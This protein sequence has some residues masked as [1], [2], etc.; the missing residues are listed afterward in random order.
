MVSREVRERI[1]K[2]LSA[3]KRPHEDVY[4]RA[5]TLVNQGEGV[6]RDA[7]TGNDPIE[8]RAAIFL[9]VGFS[10]ATGEITTGD[11]TGMTKNFA[12]GLLQCVKTSSD[13][14]SMRLA[15]RALF[16]LIQ[17]SKSYAVEIAEMVMKECKDWLDEKQKP[18]DQ[19]RLCTLVLMRD[20]ALFTRQYFLRKAPSYFGYIFKFIRDYTKHR[21]I[22][23]KS[24][25]AALT[26]ISQ[27]EHRQKNEWYQKCLE[28]ARMKSDNASKEDTLYASLLIYNE[29]M[30]IGFA[31]SEK[32]RLRLTETEKEKPKNIADTNPVTWLLDEINPQ[33]VESH[34]AQTMVVNKLDEIQ[35]TVNEAKSYRS[36]KMQDILLEIYPRLV[37][38]CKLINR[39]MSLMSL[40]PGLMTMAPKYTP[41]FQC[42]GL[43]C[44]QEKSDT[45]FLL[46]EKEPNVID[47][48]I[49]Y[50]AS[51]KPK[52]GLKPNDEPVLKFLCC[53]IESH[54]GLVISRIKEILPHMFNIGFAEGIIEALHYVVKY[55]PEMTTEVHD[56][57]LD[58]LYKQLMHQPR[59]NKLAPPTLPPVPPLN[60]YSIK[61]DDVPTMVLALKALGDFD[62]QRHSLQM[63][64]KYLT[65]AYFYCDQIEIRL[66]AV[67][68]CAKIVQPFIRIYDKLEKI[69]KAEIF[70]RIRNILESLIK[71]AVVDKEVEVR[72][73]VINAFATKD[74]EFLVHLAQ[75]DL[76]D[77]LFMT[78]YDEN[79]A[80]QEAAVGLIGA[81]AEINPAYVYPKLRKVLQETI[82]QLANSKISH[83]EEQS[84]KCIAVLA[85]KS[86]RFVMPYMYNILN[87]LEPHLIYERRT[88]GVTVHVLD[89]LSRLAPLGGMDIVSHLK[90]LFKPL[91]Q[92]LQDATSLYRREASLRAMGG[93]CQST[94]YIVDPYKDYPELLDTLLK[95]LKTELNANMRRLTIKTIGIIGALDPYTYKVFLGTVSSSR[96]RTLAVSLPTSPESDDPRLDI[97]RWINYERCTLDQFYPAI[98]IAT[99]IEMMQDEALT[100]LHK[101]IVEALFKIFMEL[102]KVNL[103]QYVDQV[104]PKLIT[105]TENANPE[106]RQFYL[107]QLKKLAPLFKLGIKSYLKD[108]FKLIATTWE[109]F[110]PMRGIVITL[111]SAIGKTLGTDFGPYVTDLCPYLLNV[112]QMDNTREKQLTKKALE[113]VAAIN[114][115]LDPHLHLIVPPIIYVIDDA[116]NT[117][118]EPVR[119]TALDTLIQILYS[120]SI[121][122]RAPLVMQMW[123]RNMS[124]KSFQDR[125]MKVLIRI[126]DQMWEQ[127]VAYCDAVRFQFLKHKIPDHQVY[128]YYEKVKVFCQEKADDL[129]PI[130]SNMVGDKQ[131]QM[132]QFPVQSYSPTSAKR[133]PLNSGSRDELKSFKTMTETIQENRRQMMLPQKPES[134]H[135]STP[136]HLNIPHLR[137]VWR[138]PLSS[139]I[140]EDWLLWIDT[141]RIEFLKHSPATSLNC[142]GSLAEAY[143]QLAK[144]LF[145]ASFMSV[146]TKLSTEEHTEIAY[147]FAECLRKC[148]YG[149]ATQAILNLAE[150]MD[151]SEKGPLPVNYPL[152]SESA[153][154]VQA[155]AKA[156]RYK[157]LE[158]WSRAADGLDNDLSYTQPLPKDC[159]QIISY[160]K[161]LNLEELALGVITYAKHLDMEVS[162]RWHEKL[163]Q[164][165]TALE[166]YKKEIE[167][168]TDNAEKLAYQLRLMRCH[169][170]LGNWNELNHLADELLKR[171]DLD[172]YSGDRDTT[173]RKQ[174]ILQIASRGAW[175]TGDFKKMNQITD[176]LNENTVEGSFLR[177]VVAVKEANY[178]TAINYIGKVRDIFDSELTAMATESYERAY[179]AIVIAQHLTELEEAIEYRT[180]PERK[181]RIAIL[182]SRRLQGM[183]LDVEQWHKTLIIRQLV[184]S[185]DELRPMWIKFAGLC[186]KRGKPN[187]ANRVLLNL[188]GIKDESVRLIEVPFPADKPPLALA[189]C[190]QLWNENYK[191]AAIEKLEVLTAN[192]NKLI[193]HNEAFNRMTRDQ[194]EPYYRVTAKCYLK[195]GDWQ[196]MF[197][198]GRGIH[199]ANQSPLPSRHPSVSSRIHTPTGIPRQAWRHREEPTEG[200]KQCYLMA[201]KLYKC[202]YKA[203]QRLAILY[204]NLVMNQTRN[205]QLEEMQNNELGHQQG[206][207]YET[208]ME[209]RPTGF[210]GNATPPDFDGDP[211][212]TNFVIHAEDWTENVRPVSDGMYMEQMHPSPGQSIILSP[213]SIGQC[214]RD[215]VICYFKAIQLAEGSRMEDT[216][217]LLMLLID[218]GHRPELSGQDIKD[219]IRKVTPE[220]WLEVAPQLIARLDRDDCVGALIKQLM[221]DV[222]KAHPHGLIYH[223]IAATRAKSEVRQRAAMEILET[224]RETRPEIVEKGLMLNEELI[225][226]AILWHELWHEALEDAS[227]IYFSAESDRNIAEM[228]KVLQPLHDKLNQSYKTLK[229]HSFIQTYYKDLSDAH[230][231]CEAYL[232]SKNQK[233][234]TQAWDLY[235]NVFKRISHQL[236]QLNSLDLNYVSPRLAEAKNLELCVPGTYDPNGRLIRIASIDHNL[237]VILSKQRPRK[238]VMRGDDGNEYIFLLKGHEDPRQDERVMQLFG[239]INSLILKDPDTCRRDL[240]IQ[241]YAI[242]GLSQSSGLIGWVPNCD[243]LHALIKDYREKKGIP[244]SV[245]HTEMQKLCA[246]YEKL[247]LMQ[248]VEVFREALRVTQ[249]ND[250]R[251]TL[252]MKSPTSE[253]WFDR[254]T[255]FTRSVACMSMVGYILGLGDRHPSNVMLDRLSGK[256]VHIDFGDC[257]EVAMRREK[258]PEKVPFR[259]TR[260]LI[261][262]ME[263]TGIEGNYRITC[264]RILRLIRQNRYSILAVLEAFVYD[265]VLNWFKIPD[266]AAMKGRQD[267]PIGRNAEQKAHDLLKQRSREAIERVKV[268]LNGYDFLPQQHIY[269]TTMDGRIQEMNITTHVDRL[270]EQA[271]LAENLCQCYI[272]F[273]PFW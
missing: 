231:F 62:F 224:V 265:P 46:K 239:L 203:W 123:L 255:N 110:P 63:F 150:F 102:P 97:I 151:H 216:L 222:A 146:W 9:V 269:S 116:E 92:H 152:L 114:P 86:P 249:G 175:T 219:E 245:E 187:I 103:N 267:D 35:R 272:G 192:L 158:M 69:Q 47:A 18:T 209:L 60:S 131:E 98:T 215:A 234:I 170:Q 256:I 16:Y 153:A 39:P 161:R 68:C 104:L 198:S 10:A 154:Q 223:L 88:I 58:L 84:A 3:L 37:G 238:L 220:T 27:R 177:A 134:Y 156:L 159:Q 213:D 181:T 183:S 163:G 137:Q 133:I 140:R 214:A 242:I 172:D 204:Y 200:V 132:Q 207:G 11:E 95:L 259:L 147:Q 271:T 29:I 218:H 236:R 57:L 50:I 76:L 250:L 270:I 73:R 167:L 221:I 74:R 201:T 51:L 25:H 15:S 195:L 260:M 107:D 185:Q 166:C 199:S 263:V 122:E 93:L 41:V 80:I 202:W 257:F 179:G 71:L 121:G 19:E 78:V 79:P 85:K 262:A 217:R 186:R 228:M 148:P 32:L 45:E 105:L 77:V 20:F 205:Q 52:Q 169:E 48:V 176:Q 182:W 229:E 124:V 135:F 36:T 261:H 115:C 144:E 128:T 240:T 268:K 31:K 6:V 248:K 108:I 33:I 227:R 252:W 143:P 139:N 109:G 237:Q 56:G 21:T 206:L 142:C 7:L 65:Q 162:G 82:G 197:G 22:A 174:R 189:I 230:A 212:P 211:A 113:C 2:F 241:R 106:F 119:S 99:L 91:L 44:L 253:V 81:L 226:C 157:E 112:V 100:L 243:T 184:L 118:P 235:Y 210:P 149:E 244:I 75:R 208:N 42:V 246:D 138:P 117:V 64:I 258:Y 67:D 247:T 101:Q 155:Y 266:T 87:S 190:K 83:L 168:E 173:D 136:T 1:V 191:Q 23:C 49:K 120:H 232:K 70:E 59:P 17:T 26:V 164:W 96:S 24:L 28:E 13:E 125:L 66:V 225:R 126:V 30:R 55:L 188:I 194:M 72:L 38:Y 127:F 129:L 264:E 61:S 180:V 4:K 193:R 196:S 145:N 5:R 12:T 130:I 90:N 53:A 233:D 178:D 94:A 89:A 8:K 171:K 34:T 14:A 165:E 160:A 273:C 54:P 254:R 251:E 141:L 40:L 43:I 111:L